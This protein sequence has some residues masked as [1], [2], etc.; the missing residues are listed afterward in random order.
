MSKS[1]HIII[2][3]FRGLT[4]GEIDKQASELDSDLNKWSEKKKLKKKLN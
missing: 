3:N 4:K 2:K 1:I